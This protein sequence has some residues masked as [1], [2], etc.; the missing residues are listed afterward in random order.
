MERCSARSG[1]ITACRKH[2][3]L[4]GPQTASAASL[5]ASPLNSGVQLF[6]HARG[7]FTGAVERKAGLLAVANGGTLFLDEVGELPLDAQAMLLRFLQ[8]GE[9]R[10][11]GSTQTTQVDVRLVSATH[12]DLEAAVERGAFREDL[13]Y[14]LR[15]VVLDVPPLRA[16][17]EDFPLL[18]EHFR[19]QVNRRYRLSIDGVTRQ[20]LKILENYPW[21]RNVRELEAVLEQA[22][23]FRSFR[24]AGG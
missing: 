12:R 19:V 10:P 24:V 7:A 17:R 18:V 6:G 3:G 14:R 23:I 4:T 8:H 13:Y 21:G 22:M 20:A 5:L 1:S 15:R 11:V 2:S 16:R 9:V